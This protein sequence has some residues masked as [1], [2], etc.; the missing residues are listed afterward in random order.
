MYNSISI[1]MINEILNNNQ[2][3]KILD[4]RDKYEYIL[5]HIPRAINIPYN[6]LITIPNNYLN[7]YTTYYIYCDN[8]IKS[9]KLCDYLSNL[10]YK[11]VDL[12]GGYKEYLDDK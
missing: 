2:N 12:I 3:K 4:I 1:K 8:G 6:Y 10:G 9:R 7:I 11:V 5:S